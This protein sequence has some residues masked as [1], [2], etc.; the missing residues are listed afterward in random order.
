MEVLNWKHLLPQ[1]RMPGRFYIASTIDV[2]SVAD[3]S[4]ILAS[5]YTT[6]LPAS[7]LLSTP[8]AATI[9]K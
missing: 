4:T 7:L 3:L 1:F 9:P 2:M 6:P 5:C 8:H